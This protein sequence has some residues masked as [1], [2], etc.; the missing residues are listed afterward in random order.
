[1]NNIYPIIITTIAGLATQIGNLMLIIPIKY[2]EKTLSFSF[3]LSLSV[4]L[5][6]SIL[7]LIP[8]GLKIAITL[9]NIPTTL[10][11]SLILLL[12]GF[13]IINILDKKLDKEE[14]L[15]RVG[16]LSM[17]SLL[18]HNIPEGILCAITSSINL[19]LGL[20]V[21]LAIM[22][23]NIPEGICISLPIYYST[24]SIKKSLIYTFLSGVGEILGA[25]IT[26]L[27]LRPLITPTI[28]YIIYL[29]TSGIMIT[30]SLTKIL[31]EG[32]KLH[33]LKYFI[34]GIII[35][36]IIILYTI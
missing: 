35:G 31:K 29:I 28:I 30:L 13:F 9:Y 22:I 34:I 6:I 24:K 10:I 32:L 12:I 15:Y 19:S 16:V 25:I 27:F 4:M 23:H 21:S 33:E 11:I 5:L 14:D 17:I 7:E 18:I 1:M 20:K 3:G 2:K 36:T 26:I 8:E